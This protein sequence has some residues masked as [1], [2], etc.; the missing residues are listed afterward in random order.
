MFGFNGVNIFILILY[1]NSNNM[2]IL[3]QKS[4]PTINYTIFVGTKY[5]A[6]PEL[7]ITNQNLKQFIYEWVDKIGMCV[8]V[9]EVDYIY[10]G[11]NEEGLRIEFINYPRFPSNQEELKAKVMDLAHILIKKSKQCN[12]TIVGPK[13]TI[14]LTDSERVE[15]LMLAR[16]IDK[17]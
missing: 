12:I 1:F 4:T 2:N 17:S 14:M 16:G 3:K 8:S 7:S 9:T 10:T 5:T 11:G 13:D 15:E 6:F